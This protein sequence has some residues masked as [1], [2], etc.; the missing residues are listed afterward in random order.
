MKYLVD[1]FVPSCLFLD[2]SISVVP[3]QGGLA[4]LQCCY[5]WGH[6]LKS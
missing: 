3:Q 2:L 5:F 1:L 6:S 4:C